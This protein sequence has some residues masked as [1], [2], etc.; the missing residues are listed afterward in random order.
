MGDVNLAAGS[1]QPFLTEALQRPLTIRGPQ[2]EIAYGLLTPDLLLAFCASKIRGIDEQV[3]RAFAKQN[4]RNTLSKKLSDLSD[5]LGLYQK[6]VPG[7]DING[8]K[9]IVE[10]YDAAILAAGKD[11][12]FGKKLAEQKA[13]FERTAKI[14]DVKGQSGEP[15]VADWEMKN[16]IDDASRIQSEL[17]QEGELEMIKL[18]SLMSQRQQALQM[19]TNMVQSLNQSSQQ[20]AANVGK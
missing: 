8:K 13:A 7:D 15:D 12:E 10:K 4:D 20:I 14:N 17:N 19:C 1:H 9:M 11:S 5:G 16:F 3:Q 18:Q 6:G 2:P